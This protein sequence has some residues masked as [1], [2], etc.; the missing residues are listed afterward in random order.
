VIEASEFGREGW[1][2]G[3]LFALRAGFACSSAVRD[4]CANDE[5]RG[6]QQ[7]E[8][9]IALEVLDHDGTVH[10][11]LAWPT[12]RWLNG[13]RCTR[14]DV[15]EDFSGRGAADAGVRPVQ[16][17]VAKRAVDV[18]FE[19]GIGLEVDGCTQ[20]QQRVFERSPE[21][22]DLGVGAVVLCGA[23]AQVHLPRIDVFLEGMCDEVSGPIHDQVSGLS[24]ASEGA[25]DER[26][27]L[28]GTGLVGEQDRGDRDA[29]EAVEYHGE[30]VRG[31][32]KESRDQGE[33][34]CQ[35]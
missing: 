13:R 10:D 14:F 31:R 12:A 7:R 34:Q 32:P 24:V 4:R 8:A 5:L 19:F 17:V 16:G 1:V 3:A 28:V 6:A 20:L 22:F 21:A 9:V 27:H 35:T 18:G 33:I 30:L 15:G 26:D 2:D 11:V 23:E 29:G 25:L